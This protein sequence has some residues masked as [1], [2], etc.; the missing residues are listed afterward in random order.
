[1]LVTFRPSTE[2][3]L[4]NV[5]AL[6]VPALLHDLAALAAA[7]VITRS[8]PDFP[9]A[10]GVANIDI[11]AEPLAVVECADSNAV[12][13]VLRLVASAGLPVAVRGGGFSPAGLGT[14]GDGIV[15]SLRPMRDIRVDRATGIVHVGA[16]VLTGELDAALTPHGLT[17]TLPVPSGPSVLGAV[18]SGGIGFTLR[19]LGLCCDALISATVV[20]ADGTIVEADDQSHPDLMWALRGG[21]GNFGVVVE[22]ALQ[23][24][25]VPAFTITHC[26]FGLSELGALLR[27]VR[28]WG[29]DL[30]RQLTVVV[31]ARSLP[32]HPGIPAQR[33]GRI[34]IVVSAIDC[35]PSSGGSGPPHEALA[36]L[37]A[38]PGMLHTTTT[39]LPP[40]RLREITDAAFPHE[41]FGV[42]TRSG[43]LNEL[44]DTAIEALVD[45]ASDLP[46]GYSVL[47]VGLLG[48]AVAAPSRPS[49]APGR[50][51]GY[52]VNLMAMWLD[53]DDAPAAT[54][55]LAAA[56]P[57]RRTVDAAAGVVPVFVS[58]D[59]LDR[60]AD[61]FGVDLPRLRK[62]KAR[63]DPHNVLNRTLAIPASESHHV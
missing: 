59:Q 49:A 8:D 9:R 17:L 25:P 52:L 13:A 60:A 26:F 62:V 37:L 35:G 31:M 53:P 51:A 27:S 20:T 47:E 46:P 55:W 7:T 18:L 36:A 63:Y 30:P 34:G 40:A 21:G 41:H 42:R 1:M 23:A 15:L 57:A 2:Q 10:A 16:G 56:D 22:A 58:A 6:A 14:V 45:A 11:S 61:T 4:P 39:T 32:P 3:G 33:H 38:L 5:T 43:W 50:D 44:S 19:A 12:A 48:G 28:E 29:P 54:G 24:R